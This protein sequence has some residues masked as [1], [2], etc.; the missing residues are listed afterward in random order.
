[1]KKGKVRRPEQSA[2]QF[3]NPDVAAAEMK[4]H[5]LTPLVPYPGTGTPWLCIHD[6]CG[7]EV[8]PSRSNVLSG[9][10]ACRMCADEK[11]GKRRRL[12]WTQVQKVFTDAGFTLLAPE[13]EYKTAMKPMSCL[14]GE[15]DREVNISY[16]DMSRGHGCRYCN[17]RFYTNKPTMVYLMK[18]STLGAL[19]VGITLQN[20]VKM[21]MCKPQRIRE[22]E[23][24]GFKVV[25]TWSFDT[26][27]PAYGVEQEV[28]RHWREDLGA[29][30]FVTP[31]QMCHHG[32]TCCAGH[33]ETASTRKVGLRRT[34][35]YIEELAA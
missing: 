27:E 25:K 8:S 15:C 9:Q 24:S 4:V 33:T 17:N 13:N 11:N 21:R 19:K 5:G 32:R 30:E 18:H 16:N 23:L 6:E 29:P 22:L 10:G 2:R 35:D 34:I 31:E 1:M 7:R 12:P 26:G 28:L 3:I 14:C 20:P